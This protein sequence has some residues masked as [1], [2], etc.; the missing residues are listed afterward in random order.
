MPECNQYCSEGYFYTKTWYDCSS[1][2][3]MWNDYYYP[4]P[5]CPKYCEITGNCP[6][7]EPDTSHEDAL[8]IMEMFDSNGDGKITMKELNK[9]IA[10]TVETSKN[11]QMVQHQNLLDGEAALWKEELQTVYG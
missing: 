2:T 9:V 4:T 11:E 3:D 6:V 5:Q 8:A 10:D 7:P 1:K